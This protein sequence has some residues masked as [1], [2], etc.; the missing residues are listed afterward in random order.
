MQYKE[1]VQRQ[2]TFFKMIESEERDIFGLVDGEPET[3]FY[4]LPFRYRFDPV[5]GI[6]SYGGWWRYFK[7]PKTTQ[8][9]RLSFAYEGYVR[10]KRN[11][12]NLPSSWDDIAKARRTKG[13]KRSKN[14]KKQWM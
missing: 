8:E 7:R 14:K 10:A 3:V 11:S 4:G 5:P 13:W 6:C 2:R 12:R 1:L 9:R